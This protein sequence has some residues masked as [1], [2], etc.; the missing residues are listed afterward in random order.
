MITLIASLHYFLSRIRSSMTSQTHAQGQEERERGMEEE[1]GSFNTDSVCMGAFAPLPEEIVCLA[2]AEN[3]EAWLIKTKKIMQGNSFIS[4]EV[5]KGTPLQI[6]K[7]V[8]REGISIPLN[9]DHEMRPL[10]GAL[11]DAGEWL[12]DHYELLHSIGIAGENCV[13]RSSALVKVTVT[14]RDDIASGNSGSVT[15]KMM[16][17]VMVKGMS[18]GTSSSSGG[19]VLNTTTGPGDE[20]VEKDV[21]KGETGQSSIAAGVS[22]SMS[23]GRIIGVE[24]GYTSP[25]NTVTYEDLGQCVAASASLSA[26]FDELRCV[27]C[28]SLSF[29]IPTFLPSF[30]FPFFF[31]SIFLPCHFPFFSL[32]CLLFH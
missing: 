18:E 7:D 16:G 27:L 26:D 10:R 13:H 6:I 2:I 32:F 24:T 25:V 20:E 4:S 30:L 19:D 17:T 5:A 1:E 3:T 14:G 21:E 23:H 8:Y 28:P 31:L 15:A 9:L 22:E 11:R 12:K 29:T